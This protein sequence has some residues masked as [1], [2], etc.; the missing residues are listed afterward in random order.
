M[1]DSGYIQTLNMLENL[2]I[3]LVN[4]LMPNTVLL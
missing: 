1:L 4:I 2:K 3:N